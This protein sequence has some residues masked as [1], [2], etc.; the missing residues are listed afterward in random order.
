MTALNGHETSSEIEREAEIVR[1]QLTQTLD[2]LRDNLTPQHLADEVLGHAKYGA[3]ALLETLGASAMKHPLPALLIGAG[4]AAALITTASGIAR[5]ATDGHDPVPVPYAPATAAPQAAPP[6]ATA[7]RW[8]AL[9][10][11]PVVTAI[12]GMMLGRFVAAALPRA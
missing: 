2:R 11:R 12:L 1:A 7:S 3:S 10:D 5:A 6:P 4:C 8:A 9:G